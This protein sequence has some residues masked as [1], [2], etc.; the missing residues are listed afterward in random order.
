MPERLTPKTREMEESNSKYRFPISHDDARRLYPKAKVDDKLEY[1]EIHISKFWIDLGYMQD[2]E[3][4]RF[5]AA[6]K[7]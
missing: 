3:S 2:N 6:R 5:V 1:F 4:C 7:K